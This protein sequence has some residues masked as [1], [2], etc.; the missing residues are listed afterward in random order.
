MNRTEN[1]HKSTS[2]V[3]VLTWSCGKC[4]SNIAKNKYPNQECIER[5]LRKIFSI[6]ATFMCQ[7]PLNTHRQIK[8]EDTSDYRRETDADEVWV[9]DRTEAKRPI[10]FFIFCPLHCWS[11]WPQMQGGWD[12]GWKGVQGERWEVFHGM[13]GVWRGHR[14][15]YIRRNWNTDDTDTFQI[16][17]RAHLCKTS[18][19]KLKNPE[20]PEAGLLLWRCH[21]TSLNRH[22]LGHWP[23]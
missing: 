14:R 7:I 21:M 19:R 23:H 22:K 9:G 4:P 8:I 16:M 10:P 6:N 12:G 1:K 13:N 2:F 20:R 18:H 5:S 15:L 3:L 17:T 11:M